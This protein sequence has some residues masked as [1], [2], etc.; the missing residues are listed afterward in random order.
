[1]KNPTRR[2]LEEMRKHYLDE[3]SNAMTYEIKARIRR[4]EVTIALI[5]KELKQYETV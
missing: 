4:L 5:N 2:E 3:L 1:V